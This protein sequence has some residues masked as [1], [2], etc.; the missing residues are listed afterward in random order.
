MIPVD[1]VRTGK[2]QGQCTEAAVASILEVSLDTVPDLWGGQ[3]A[4]EERPPRRWVQLLGLILAHGSQ[5][6][7][8]NIPCTP[9]NDFDLDSLDLP[10]DARFVARGFHLL[11]GENPDGVGHMVVAKDGAVVHDPNP[12]RRGIVAVEEVI[13]FIPLEMVEDNLF[14][15]VMRDYKRKNGVWKLTMSEDE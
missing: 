15:W 1:Q 6:V 2:P 13:V 14:H 9:L 10:R 12:S 5:L 7:R 4:D 11:V 3:S 8:Y